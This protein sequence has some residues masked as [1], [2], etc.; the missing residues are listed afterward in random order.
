M[1]PETIIAAH[2]GLRRQLGLGSTTAAAIAGIVA[3]GIILTPA[4]MV[5]ALGSPFLLLIVW[6]VIGAMTMTAALCYGEL[7]ARFPRAVSI[8]HFQTS[9]W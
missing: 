7:A 1:R 8:P 6:L 3:V 4:E 2:P 9:S 5:K